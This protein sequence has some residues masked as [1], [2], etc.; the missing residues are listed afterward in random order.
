MGTRQALARLRGF[1][2]AEQEEKFLSWVSKVMNRFGGYMLDA[3]L[4]LQVLT[5]VLI[6]FREPE[7]VRDAIVKYDLFGWFFLLALITGIW[8]IARR[9]ISTRAMQAAIR[10]GIWFIKIGAPIR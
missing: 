1:H 9:K 6:L 3:A 8:G 5:G 10:L 7:P 4:L 2:W